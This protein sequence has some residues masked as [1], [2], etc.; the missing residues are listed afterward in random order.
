MGAP[1]KSSI[2]ISQGDDDERE[3]VWESPPGTPVDITGA[4]IRMQ[5]RKGPADSNPEVIGIDD[6]GTT[7]GVIILS[8]PTN[9][10]FETLFNR[11]ATKKLV[12]KQKY[13][14]DVEIT[15][16]GIRTTIVAGNVSVYL[17]ITE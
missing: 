17:E 2:T 16:D 12:D 3:F 4:S 9:G 6:T 15:L 1:G 8:D 13:Q 10:T 5:I 14:Y 11:D 7:D